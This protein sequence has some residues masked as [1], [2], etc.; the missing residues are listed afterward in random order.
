MACNRNRFSV[1]RMR[2]SSAN[3]F[4]MRVADLHRTDIRERSCSGGAEFANLSTRRNFRSKRSFLLCQFHRLRFASFAKFHQSVSF[5]D[6]YSRS[7]KWNIDEH[8]SLCVR[9][10]PTVLRSREREGISIREEPFTTEFRYR[11]GDT[12]TSPNSLNRR[13]VNVEFAR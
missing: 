9:K 11:V 7:D 3:A 6:R 10:E 13:D 2:N 12:F 8:A 4:A 5:N 1:I